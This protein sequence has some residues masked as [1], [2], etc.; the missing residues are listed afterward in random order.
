[1]DGWLLE[2]SFARMPQTWGPLAT[3]SSNCVYSSVT[4]FGGASMSSSRTPQSCSG[5]QDM[6]R[7]HSRT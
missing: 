7:T 1:M 4:L 6:L 2:W 5:H 3:L